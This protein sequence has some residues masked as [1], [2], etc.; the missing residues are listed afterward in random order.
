MT[1]ARI[2]RQR[3]LPR[4]KE[5]SQTLLYNALLIIFLF[6]GCVGSELPRFIYYT[7]YPIWNPLL[8]ALICPLALLFGFAVILIGIKKM[9]A[10]VNPILLAAFLLLS[11]GAMVGTFSTP[12]TVAVPYWHHP[13]VTFDPAAKWYYAISSVVSFFTLYVLFNFG[14]YGKTR[15]GAWLLIYEGMILFA[16]AAIFYS[17]ATEGESYR[18]IFVG[19][20]FEDRFLPVSWVGQKNAFGRYIFI[21]FLAELYLLY[22]DRHYWRYLMT[23]Y[24]LFSLSIT[25][26]KTAIIAAGAILLCYLV[27]MAVL[28]WNKRRVIAIIHIAVVVLLTG[29]AF[30]LFLIPSESLGLIGKIV[31]LIKKNAD[32]EGGGTITSRK[33]IWDCCIAVWNDN[34]ISRIFGNGSY[35]FSRLIA[36]AMDIRTFMPTS[37]NAWIE[38]LGSGGILALAVQFVLTAYFFVVVIKKLIKKQSHVV[39]SLIFFLGL[40]FHAVLESVWFFDTTNDALCF[41]MLTIMPALSSHGSENGACRGQGTNWKAIGTNLSRVLLLLSPSILAGALLAPFPWLQGIL[42]VAT[43]VIQFAVIWFYKGN[44]RRI[45]LTGIMIIVDIGTILLA[46]S[47]SF[48]ASFDPAA[49]IGFPSLLLFVLASLTE[50]W[51]PVFDVFSSFAP[52]ESAYQD[53]LAYEEAAVQQ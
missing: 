50:L 26:D 43:F 28:H 21:A 38:A 15:R 16:L 11:I 37:H 32:I 29:A 45:V 40:T 1:C 5:G 22:V 3:A 23:G 44:S 52:L 17:Y 7:D 53:V 35:A 19:R 10:K 14:P 31:D 13:V 2:E 33:V 46:R 9:G 39:L 27:F 36:P 20:V 34:P 30:V 18:I 6:L 8:L 48:A 49:V 41:V 47:F 51:V 24:F 4:A 42:A 25:M 12:D